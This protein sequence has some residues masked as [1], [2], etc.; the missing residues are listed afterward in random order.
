MKRTLAMFLGIA[1]VL[2]LFAA[3]ADWNM[4]AG[5]K[6]EKP[7]EYTIAYPGTGWTGLGKKFA[8][9]PGKFY[10]LSWEGK[11]EG[12]GSPK[13]QIF[14]LSGERKSYT[15]C[16]L[17]KNEWAS[18]SFY[19]YSGNST[20]L[21]IRFILDPSQAGTIFLRN[22][23]WEELTDADLK[24]NLIPNANFE[25]PLSGF[26]RNIDWKKP[27]PPAKIVTGQN[28]ITGTQSLQLNFD[29]EPA[30]SGARGVQTSCLP[31]IPGATFVLSFW[32]D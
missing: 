10:K 30:Q 4:G 3:E 12:E 19:A 31:A 28:F 5:W 25:A 20:S 27:I 1:S 14:M 7:G 15:V 21:E 17:P 23:K 29:G 32:D 2:S 24:K 13:F 26:W 18:S 8:T 16:L 11:Q 9:A 22:L 6:T